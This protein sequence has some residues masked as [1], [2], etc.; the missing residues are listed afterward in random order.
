MDPTATETAVDPNAVA[1]RRS[2]L[3]QALAVVFGT[4]TGV[5]PVFAGLL[6]VLDPLRHRGKG[7]D[8]AGPAFLKITT[9]DA[10]PTDGT[11]RQSPVIADLQDA[12]T[13]TPNARVG[14]V[15]LRRTKDGQ[16]QAISTICPHAGCF[17]STKT[18]GSF[19]CPCHDSEFD[20]DGKK[21]EKNAEGRATVSPRDLDT[22]EVK[23]E[24][25]NVMVQYVRYRTGSAKKV[26]QA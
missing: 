24:N 16:V 4:I 22:L 18:D 9:L 10:L 14:A 17:V 8:A 23:V 19:K 26:P 6:T 2:F 7:G 21:R 3:T 5:V 13:K 12:W 25:D 11:W 15:F 1:P 20:A